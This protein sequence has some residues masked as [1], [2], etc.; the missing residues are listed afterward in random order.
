MT[1]GLKLWVRVEPCQCSLPDLHPA[2]TSLEMA[3]VGC[4]WL[5]N[6]WPYLLPHRRKVF[7]GYSTY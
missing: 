6:K 4:L 3:V 1:T 2:D 5:L 7:W